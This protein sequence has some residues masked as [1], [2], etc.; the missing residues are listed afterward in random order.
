M[1]DTGIL[2]DRRSSGAEIVTDTPI[3]H[4]LA[5]ADT[6]IFYAL[7]TGR[8]LP[9]QT[10]AAPPAGLAEFHRDPLTSP[11]PIQA[12]P[13]PRRPISS[14]SRPTRSTSAGDHSPSRHARR[15]GRHHLRSV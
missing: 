10:Q 11:I 12:V 3:F 15:T 1:S 6:P 14:I 13:E 8:E 7:T 4:A 9:A 2:L 5:A